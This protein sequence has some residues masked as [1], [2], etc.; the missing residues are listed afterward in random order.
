MR[1]NFSRNSICASVGNAKFK[2][3]LRGRVLRLKP[4]LLEAK[5]MLLMADV[6]RKI[7]GAL[8]P[9]FLNLTINREKFLL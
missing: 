9:N 3:A 4:F 2:G 5:A 6:V 7:K 8:N 1:G